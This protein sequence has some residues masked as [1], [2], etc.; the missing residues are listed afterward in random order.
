MKKVLKTF[1]LTV[2]YLF[3]LSIFGWM[4]FHISEGDKKFGF[5]SG[6]V[7]FMYTFPDLFFQSI[8]EVKSLPET[9]IKTPEDFKSINNLDFDF[10]VLST[11]SDINDSRSIVL[12][13]LKNDS[14]LYKWTVENPYEDFYRILNPLLFP[15]KSLV[16]AFT[17]H[18]GL[19]RID[20]L[21]NIIWKQDSIFAHHS[22]TLDSSGDIWIC[23]TEPVYYATGLY[24]MNGTSIFYID[25]YITKIDAETGRIL[26]H[27]SM[28]SIL[29][30]NNLS[31]YLI[32][33][34]NVS[35]PIHI[36][37]VEPAIKS[38]QYYKEGDLFI[39]A[40][41]PSFIMH[42]RPSTNKIMN[43]IE[44]PFTSQHDVD[45]L[46]D[47]TLVIFNNNFYTIWSD[48]INPP[49]P[50]SSLLEIAGD[51]YSNIVRYDFAN[52]SLSFIGDSIFRA[53]EIFT[54]GEGVM[55][56]VD[57]STYFVEEQN[58]GL[59]WIIKD[60]KVIY[61]NVLKSQHEGYHHLL[62]W[63]RVIKYNG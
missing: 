52:D 6:P 44:G 3:T 11:Y 12:L 23:S 57:P 58:T 43:M 59:I 37:D 18:T 36:N 5:L 55:E 28:T 60:D 16:Y 62:N 63:I 61:K 41:N 46:N 49:P 48:D 30:E 7:K 35:D 25:N 31:Y 50:D 26:F 19:R 56:F 2:I 39:S 27:K 54:H 24:K 42:Y 1:S 9:F 51:F 38:T 20:S 34:A 45:F 32:K 8:K 10:I 13:N 47:S 53:N 4:A 29:T 22:M 40:R 33:S 15:E 17:F 14:I 21:T